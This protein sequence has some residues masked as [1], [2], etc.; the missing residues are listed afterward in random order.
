M[1]PMHQHRIQKPSVPFCVALCHRLVQSQPSPKFNYMLNLFLLFTIQQYDKGASPS[2]PFSP[3]YLTTLW[4]TPNSFT[5][6]SKLNMLS[7]QSLPTSFS[8]VL[9]EHFKAKCLK[10]ANYCRS[11]SPSLWV[12]SYLKKFQ[13]RW[14]L[15]PNVNNNLLGFKNSSQSRSIIGRVYSNMN[16]TGSR[17]T[18]HEEQITE[19]IG[20]QEHRKQ[21]F[22][23]GV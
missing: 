23:N 22:Q 14:H 6:C 17:D 4:Q 9:I 15:H 8:K 20:P 7:C 16:S 19:S 21:F 11:I 3:S 12:V 1:N 2:S 10:S 13:E 18:R 5:F